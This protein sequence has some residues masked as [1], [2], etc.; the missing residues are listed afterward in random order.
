MDLL[1][2]M[3]SGNG[4]E[5]VRGVDSRDIREDSAKAIDQIKREDAMSNEKLNVLKH[6]GNRA[7]GIV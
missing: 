1:S 2:A 3:I 6:K 7:V 5:E 4:D